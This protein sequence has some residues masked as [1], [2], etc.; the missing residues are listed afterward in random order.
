MAKTL[1]D[2]YRI[3][4]LAYLSDFANNKNKNDSLARNKNLPSC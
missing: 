1:L 3:E 2:T 4:G